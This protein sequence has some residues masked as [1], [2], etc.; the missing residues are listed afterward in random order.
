MTIRGWPP[1]PSLS[2]SRAY[3]EHDREH[4]RLVASARERFLSLSLSLHLSH[5]LGGGWRS[6]FS[7]GQ[8]FIR[9]RRDTLRSGCSPERF[10]FTL[11]RKRAPRSCTLCRCRGN[12][13]ITSPR[14]RIPAGHF[15]RR[16]VDTRNPFRGIIARGILVRVHARI[17]PCS[18][19]FGN[20]NARTKS[21]AAKCEIG[22]YILP[23]C[24]TFRRVGRI[25]SRGFEN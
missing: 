10:L 19:I 4:A 12:A 15:L 22:R 3:H 17:L 8:K 25:H 11:T 24:N 9:R 7:K 1:L 21:G 20:E 14:N 13:V 2:S 23:S 6:P 16:H 18:R 5:T